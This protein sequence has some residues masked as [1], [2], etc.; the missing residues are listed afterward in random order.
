M[1]NSKK[2]F[3]LAEVL[4]TLT[5]IGVIA[6]LTLPLLMGGTNTASFKTGYKKAISVLSQAIMMNQSK[7]LNGPNLCAACDQAGATGSQAL[8]TYFA[9]SINTLGAPAAG[10]F[11]SADGMVFTFTHSA[12]AT[13][14]ADDTVFANAVCTVMVDVNGAKAPNALTTGAT[15]TTLKDRFNIIIQSSGVIPGDAGAL[16]VSQN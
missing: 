12:T 10:V 2:G 14:C 16:A 3:T 13:G 6:A 1:K 9:S 11:T 4:V 15:S 8:A 7:D 5:I